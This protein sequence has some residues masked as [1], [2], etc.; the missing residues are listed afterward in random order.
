MS[1][2]PWQILLA[3]H[4]GD[5]E[6]YATLDA[7]WSLKDF[8]YSNLILSPTG[9]WADTNAQDFVRKHV[10]EFD[11]DSFFASERDL[12][13]QQ[14]TLFRRL[15]A[16]RWDRITVN[17]R[18]FEISPDAH[19]PDERYLERRESVTFDYAQR[20]R[21]LGMFSAGSDGGIPFNDV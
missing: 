1:A 15:N 21:D 9:V 5:I 16:P 13:R 8:V 3:A 11:R 4:T 7:F 12:R 20:Q 18:R 10:D 19:V 2:P 17:R 6:S 14:P